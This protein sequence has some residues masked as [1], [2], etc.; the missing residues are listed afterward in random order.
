MGVAVCGKYGYKMLFTY[1]SSRGVP[2]ELGE[3]ER[4]YTAALAAEEKTS[5]SG[6]QGF[7]ECAKLYRTIPDNDPARSTANANAEVC[8]YN[9][10]YAFGNAGKFKSQGLAALKSAAAADARMASY[11]LRLLEDPPVDCANASKKSVSGP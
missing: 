3:A 7:L 8:Y 1:A 11:I 6:A 4:A 5:G 9:A 2:S 10:V